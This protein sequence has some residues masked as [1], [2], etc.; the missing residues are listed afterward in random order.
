MQLSFTGTE[1][2]PPWWWCCHAVTLL[3]H[4][5]PAG[6]ALHEKSRRYDGF[7]KSRIVGVA[8]R[9]DTKHWFVSSPQQQPTTNRVLRLE[10]SDQ[11]L[12]VDTNRKKRD[13]SMPIE[14]RAALPREGGGFGG[15]AS[16]WVRSFHGQSVINH[17]C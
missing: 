1:H 17:R 14:I 3:R 7:G 15:H 12:S 4:D 8:V 10:P 5:S 9:Q 2:P 6:F 11:G 16:R 13:G